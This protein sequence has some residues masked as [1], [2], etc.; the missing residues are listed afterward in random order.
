VSAVK[1]DARSARLY[2]ESRHPELQLPAET[3]ITEQFWKQSAIEDSA[4]VHPRRQS[5]WPEHKL[6]QVVKAN[7][8]CCPAKGVIE[9]PAMSLTNAAFVEAK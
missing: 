8:V 9:L 7:G 5:A 6:E 3:A 2:P 4:A 1:V